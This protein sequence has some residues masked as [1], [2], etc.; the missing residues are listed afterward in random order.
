[1]KSFVNISVVLCS[2]LFFVNLANAS[3]SIDDV[4]FSGRVGGDIR[5][6][7]SDKSL[8]NVDDRQNAQALVGM[9]H[10][11]HVTLLNNE[12]DYV[13]VREVDM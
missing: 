7:Y 1:M 9:T 6:I 4:T 2:F 10:S 12:I 3:L 13:I 11:S 5:A 8:T